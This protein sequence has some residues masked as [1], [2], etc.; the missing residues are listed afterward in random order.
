MEE[1]MVSELPPSE[2][3]QVGLRSHHSLA[4]AGCP[5]EALD[6]MPDLSGPDFAE[7]QVGGEPRCS[8]QIRAIPRARVLSQA[9]AKEVTHT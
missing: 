7:V 3:A 9:L 2:L 8:R 4:R 1:Q 5:D 6:R